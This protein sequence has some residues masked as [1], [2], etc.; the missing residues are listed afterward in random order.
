MSGDD[1]GLFE[2]P[3][4]RLPPGFAASLDDPPAQPAAARPAATMVLL[5][6]AAPAAGSEGGRLNEDAGAE[7][8]LLQRE[9]T[10]AFV[11]GAYVFPG[12]RVDAGD[13][14]PRLAEQARGR[15]AEWHPPAEYW[16]AAVRETFEEAG[17]LL[18][19]AGGEEWARDASSDRAME[20]WREELLQ[21]RVV[22]LEV[23][24][25]LDAHVALDDVV[26]FAHWIT[27][28]IEPRRYDTRFFLAR[29]PPG[30]SVRA[31]PR[32]MNDAVW[33]TPEDAL[34]RF[35]NG[36]LP[37][38]FPTVRTLETLAGQQSAAAALD[39]FRGREVPALEPR[40]VRTANGVAITLD[41]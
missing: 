24:R 15:P 12:G 3:A 40:L 17:V 37:M 6:D 38:V 26:Y 10:T 22:L 16:M 27:P 14:D 2:I 8:L 31:D 4:E 7:V 5:R 29:L 13:A 25:G 18:A 33:L 21:D 20:A 32:E 11:P 23:L 1:A 19:R 9:R 39:A 36:E 35:R 28:A 41:D 34:E 30:R